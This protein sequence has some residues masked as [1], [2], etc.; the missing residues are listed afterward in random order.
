MYDLMVLGGGPAGY[1]AAERAGE[2]GLRVVLFEKRSLGGVCLN[3]GC[4]PSKALLNSAK[5]YESALHGAA[6]GVTVTG[7]ALDHAAVIARK[8]KVVRT[9]VAGVKAKMKHA[10]VTVV[11][12]EARLTGRTDE[13]FAAQCAGDTY[14]ARRLLIATGSEPA[15]PPIPGLRE[16]LA[17]GFALTNREVLDLPAAPAHLAIIGGGVIGLE[18]ASYY[19]AAGSRVTVVE[20]LDHIAGNTD[21]EIGRRLQKQLEAA[22]IVFHLSAR[23]TAVG[24]GA[25]VFEKDGQASRLPCDNVLVSVGRRPVTEGYGLE[26]LSVALER[27]AIATDERL[28]TSVPGV[29]AAGDVNGRSMLAHTAYREAEV[30]VSDMLGRRD[31]MR[32]DAIPAV[33]YTKP[34]VACVGVTPLEAADAEVIDL[35]F[36]YSG[37][38]V[39]E[40]E[41]GDGLARVLFERKTGRL[42]GAHLYGSY[43]SE[44]IWGAA[45]LIEGEFRAADIRE[46]VFPH[47]TVSEI[48]REAAWASKL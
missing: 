28:R 9:L 22:G 35:P 43:A 16:A 42:I 6:Y 24:E 8:K 21:A 20:M 4:I 5:I 36:Q 3:E 38:Y 48:L 45:A 39:A 46:I 17:S 34:E 25:L 44:I 14:A 26:T 33:I 10:G 12:G 40:V 18:M 7:A 2:A 37:R 31:T 19:H 13:G 41:R 15:T 11:E 30:A 1:C 27:G 32:Y 47:P 23:V 29:W